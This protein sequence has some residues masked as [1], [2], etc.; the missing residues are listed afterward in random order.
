MHNRTIL[1][2]AVG[3][4]LAALVALTGSVA[5]GTPASAASTAHTTI[6]WTSVSS[7]TPFAAD[8]VAAFNKANPTITVID[9][10]QSAVSNVHRALISEQMASGST[11]PD[12][13][14]LDQTW[15][16]EGTLN[17]W[18]VPLTN[19]IPASYYADMP[20][21]L[22]K[23]YQYKGVQVAVPY[24]SDV[25]I[26]YYRKDL[27]TKYNL[28]VPTT[29]E[30]L[31]SEAKTLQKDGAVKYGF[32]Y[33]GAN[34]ESTSQFWCS[35]IN[36]AGGATINGNY[37]ASAVNSAAG[38]KALNFLS[39]TISSG[40]TPEAISTFGPTEV[41]TEFAQ[42]T[43]AFMAANAYQWPSI[44]GTGLA[45]KVGVAAEPT[46]AGEPGPGAACSG[47]DGA[48]INPYSKHRQADVK[49]LE[50]L[51]SEQAQLIISTVGHLQPATDTVLSDP[52]VD[53]V[54][55]V[56][57]LLPHLRIINRQSGTK[58][59]PDLTLAISSNI[60]AVIS[61]SEKPAA[62]LVDMTT[63]I[64]AALKGLMD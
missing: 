60:N 38:L 63:Q 10:P 48:W 32:L 26:M 45:S 59:Y 42:G 3:V 55:P 30:Q 7:G 24:F 31:A 20:P 64:N 50:F 2:P 18:D 57:A 54:D 40:I 34:N 19:L 17:H 56:A 33:F 25:M 29:W 39:S 23:G 12:V 1:R 37:T 16:A 61:G 14:S 53:A 5:A 4:S 46:F 21:G 9:E 44:V 52:S 49:F 28:P 51:T 8:L 35:L 22:V 36:D 13:Y 15:P 11:T 27:L 6:V 47:G 43:S 62:A 41:G 58:Y